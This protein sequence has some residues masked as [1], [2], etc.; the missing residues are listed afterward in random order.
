MP[1]YLQ[2]SLSNAAPSMQKQFSQL[3]VL[4]PAKTF[5]K[6]SVFLRRQFGLPGRP[7]E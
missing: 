6:Q 4:E 3:Y 1:L 5:P 2:L 7:L